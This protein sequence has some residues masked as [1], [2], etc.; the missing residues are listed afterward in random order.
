MLEAMRI[1]AELVS[2]IPIRESV[3]DAAVSVGEG[4]PI[5]LALKKGGYFPPGRSYPKNNEFRS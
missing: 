3:Y 5:H 2:N 4:S 1:S